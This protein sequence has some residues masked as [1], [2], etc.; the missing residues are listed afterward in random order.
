MLIKQFYVVHKYMKFVSKIIVYYT[1]KTPLI[2]IILIVYSL[3]YLQKKTVYS[4][5]WK[6]SVI[7]QVYI[8]VMGKVVIKNDLP[9]KM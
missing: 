7:L 5:A 2:L 4:S 8:Q 6:N 1:Y 9:A 3:F